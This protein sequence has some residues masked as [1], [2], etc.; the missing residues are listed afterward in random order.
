MKGTVF[1]DAENCKSRI[2]DVFHKK[3]IKGLDFNTYDL[4]GLFDEIFEEH[5][6]KYP[7]LVYRAKPERHVDIQKYSEKII[8]RYREFGGSLSR[9]GFE[10]IKAGV[11][12]A[13]Y[14]TKDAKRPEYRE[15]GVDIRLAVDM[16]TM[17]CDGKL[18]EALLV[19]SDSDYQ[20]AVKELRNR[21]VKIIYVGFEVNPN[22]G[23]I[24]KTD[25]RFII[26]NKTVLK[27]ASI[28]D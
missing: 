1:I 21:G 26:P 9:Q 4:K 16:V 15:K 8:K 25:D 3:K 22:R 20:P 24:A 17:A 7:R 11:L 6:H 13:D 18:D 12:R 2:R 23:L 27:F 28:K 14:R 19:A 5:Q 10:V